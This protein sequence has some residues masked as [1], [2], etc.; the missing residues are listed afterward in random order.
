MRPRTGITLLVFTLAGCGARYRLT[1]NDLTAQ[2]S[3]RDP[4]CS[5]AI[6]TQRFDRPYVELGVLDHVSGGAYPY[7]AD[8]FR[9]KVQTLVCEAGGDGVIAQVSLL[10]HYVGGTVVRWTSPPERD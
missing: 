10:G 1:P 8:A 4:G 9:E 5:V 3:P 2:L 7:T 6:S